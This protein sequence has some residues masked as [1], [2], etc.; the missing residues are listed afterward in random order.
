MVK[1]ELVAK[2]RYMEGVSPVELDING[3]LFQEAVKTLLIYKSAHMPGAD[4]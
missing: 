4:L 2:P 3:G 1:P